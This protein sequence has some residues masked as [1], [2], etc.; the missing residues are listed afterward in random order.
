LTKLIKKRRKPYPRVRKP[1]KTVFTPSVWAQWMIEKGWLAPLPDETTVHLRAGIAEFRHRLALE[2]GMG[3]LDNN[4][5]GGRESCSCWALAV[6]NCSGANAG[7]CRP[8][9]D[10]TKPYPRA[11]TSQNS[12]NGGPVSAVD[13]RD[14]RAE[15]DAR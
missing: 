13:G 1:R 15:T 3:H 2:P 14:G 12:L 11:Q 10:L 7:K 5:L 8:Q 9:S 6:P 4:A